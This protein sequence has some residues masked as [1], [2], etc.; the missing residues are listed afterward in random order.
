[1]GTPAYSVIKARVKVFF[2][3]YFTV[4]IVFVLS[5]QATTLITQGCSNNNS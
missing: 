3:F 5:F 2:F 4:K 1:M